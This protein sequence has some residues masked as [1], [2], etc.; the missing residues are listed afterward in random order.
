VLFVLRT[1]KAARDVYRWVDYDLL[2]KAS[3]A[4]PPL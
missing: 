1:E 2:A 3:F 4:R